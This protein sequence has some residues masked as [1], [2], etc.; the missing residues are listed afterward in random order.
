MRTKVSGTKELLIAISTPTDYGLGTPAILI[1]KPGTGKTSFVESLHSAEMP[2]MTLIASIHDATDFSGLPYF[3]EGRTK[4]APPEW[5]FHFDSSENGILFIDEI[6]TCMPQVQAALLRVIL[7]R[8][9]GIKDLPPRVRIVAAAN[10]PDEI[11][12]GFQLTPPLANRFCHIAW[13]MT[14]AAFSQGMKEGFLCAELYEF[15]TKEH[16]RLKRRWRELVGTFTER[17]SSM[18]NTKPGDQEQA[19]ASPR[20]WDM[21]AGLMASSDILGIAPQLGRS[22]GT[23]SEDTTATRLLVGSVGTAATTAFLGFLQNLDLPDPVS[24]LAGKVKVDPG[25]LQ[26]DAL[27]VFFQSLAELL[28]ALSDQSKTTDRRRVKESIKESIRVMKLIESINTCGKLDCVFAS[29]KNLFDCNWLQNS[30]MLSYR[31]EDKALTQELDAAIK[32]LEGTDLASYI[33]IVGKDV[34]DF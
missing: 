6:T 13:E 21:A 19:F 34:S 2:V 31:Y 5:S 12:G 14:P 25:R 3:S 26:D 8:K 1:G 10:P 32:S 22:T 18:L 4:F 30:L 27:Y 28:P 15:D 16:A 29:V 24:F 7:H 9:V 11:C 17:S 23:Q 33:S 20:S